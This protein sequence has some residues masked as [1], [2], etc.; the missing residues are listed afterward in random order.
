[1]K[2]Q[3]WGRFF[4]LLFLFS[5]PFQLGRHFWFPWCYVLGERID[6]LSPTIFLPDIFLILAFVFLY[7]WKKPR[8]W[9]WVGVGLVILNIIFAYQK[10]V[11]FFGWL[12]WGRI[13]FSLWL[14]RENKKWLKKYWPGIICFWLV[15]E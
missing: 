9:F 4:L 8:W 13:L 2:R 10:T 1:M 14:V 7:R 6:Y 3:N 5:L 11:A 15:V 12:K